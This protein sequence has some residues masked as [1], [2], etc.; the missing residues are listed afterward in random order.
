MTRLHQP[1]Q[2]QSKRTSSIE[3][4][5]ADKEGSERM[6]MRNVF[7]LPAAYGTD[8]DLQASKWTHTARVRADATR[9]QPAM[10]VHHRSP[11]RA[12]RKADA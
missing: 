7:G 4:W 11:V 8:A 3:V 10:T 5:D 1:Q 6:D 9:N 12:G 2:I